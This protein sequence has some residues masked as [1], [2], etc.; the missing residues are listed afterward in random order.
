MSEA[1]DVISRNRKFEL[2]RLKEKEI[3]IKKLIESYEKGDFKELNGFCLGN[4]RY[5]K[6]FYAKP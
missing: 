6:N 4:C 2:K 1:E 3:E 5:A